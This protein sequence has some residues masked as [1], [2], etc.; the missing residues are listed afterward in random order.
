MMKTT[1][2]ILWLA[3]ASISLVFLQPP[4]AA[5]SRG[6]IGLI[7]VNDGSK[8]R[9]FSTVSECVT[10]ENFGRTYRAQMT[11]GRTL[12]GLAGHVIYWIDYRSAGASEQL[13]KFGQEFAKHAAFAE[14]KAEQLERDNPPPPPGGGGSRTDVL[15]RLEAAGRVYTKVRPTKLRD[16]MIG[17]THN[18]GGLNLPAD[19]FSHE[20]LQRLS[21]IG[22]D[23][24]A[25]PGFLDL[26]KSFE[27]TVLAGGKVLSG[28][29]L[30]RK[31][32]DRV[33]LVSD[34]GEFRIRED[35]ISSEML[36]RVTAAKGR[37]EAW[38]K[39]IRDRQELRL[40]ALK[41]KNQLEFEREKARIERE[42]KMAEAVIDVGTII[43]DAAV[44]SARGRCSTPIDFTWV[45]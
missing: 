23:L 43:F 19:L 36:D 44:N 27:P 14:A 45:V 9:E 37:Y 6:P 8:T 42:T 17:F 22:P 30:D 26:L 32:G 28:V 34:E 31:E 25:S 11:N 20:S 10:F 2:Q 18:A 15:D 5:Q 1:K 21:R 29:R 41:L 33:Y 16:R 24:I 4:A 40:Q 7:V 3:L 12:S 13:R 38:L 39:A 35:E